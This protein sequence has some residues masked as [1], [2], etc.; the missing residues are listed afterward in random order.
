MP[1]VVPCLMWLG[2]FGV[3]IGFD[4]HIKWADFD[5]VKYYREVIMSL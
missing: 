3:L 1:C 5:C 2:G 4:E